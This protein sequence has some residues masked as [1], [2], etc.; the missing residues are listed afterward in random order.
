MSIG[1]S[2]DDNYM[3]D[4]EAMDLDEAWDEN[5][6]DTLATNAAGKTDP[7]RR[8]A[9]R[10]AIEEYWEMKRLRNQ[11]DDVYQDDKD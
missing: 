10:R 5:D 1:P 7:K 11:L 6:F 3:D 2:H 4:V 8:S 9:S